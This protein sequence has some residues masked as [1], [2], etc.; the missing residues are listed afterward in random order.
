MKLSLKVV[1]ELKLWLRI[2]SG[3]VRYLWTP[4]EFK[5]FF[6]FSST[7][8]YEF[9]LAQLF[10]SIVSSP[11]PSVSNFSLPYFPDRSG[12]SIVSTFHVPKYIFSFLFL[13]TRFGCLLFFRPA[14]HNWVFLAFW[15]FF[16][17]EVAGLAPNPQPGG[18]GC[19]SSSGFYPLTCP[20]WAA[21][22]VATLPPA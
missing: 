9:W 8:L 20:A 12:W 18:P 5:F 2:V 22:P 11:A 16:R 10:L 17:G 1:P 3:L 4:S 21:L 15:V 6:F 19:L 7:T 13:S 14:F